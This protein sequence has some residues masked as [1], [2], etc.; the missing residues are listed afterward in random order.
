MG[1]VL[2][3]RKD[4]CHGAPVHLLAETGEYNVPCLEK[5]LPGQEVTLL[6]VAGRQQGIVSRESLSLADISDHVF[7]NRQRGSGT[8]ML[9]DYELK[10]Q[11]ISSTDIRGYERE[12]TTHLGVALAVKTG[13]VDM[14][15]CVYSAAKALGLAFVPVAEE[16]YEI[17]IRSR[18]L[19]DPGIVS[20]CEAV[21]SRKFKEIL[22]SFGGYDTGKTG[23][24]RMIKG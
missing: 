21:G 4:E 22:S 13:E 6:Y 1:G 7:I 2:A 23:T 14:G 8:R 19:D 10:K 18:H 11:G 9:L 12:A 5:Y 17:A 20:L 3:L 24:Q 15:M 16:R